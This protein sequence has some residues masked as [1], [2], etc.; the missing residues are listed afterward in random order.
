M[1]AEVVML[2]TVM[3]MVMVELWKTQRFSLIFLMPVAILRTDT[4]NVNAQTLKSSSSG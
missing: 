4:S 1:E 2:M 3:V